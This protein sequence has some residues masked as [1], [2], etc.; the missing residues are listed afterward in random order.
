MVPSSH[1]RMQIATGHKKKR[2]EM[3]Q[4]VYN[5]SRIDNIRG[6]FLITMKNNFTVCENKQKNVWLI[7]A[8]STYFCFERVNKFD[9]KYRWSLP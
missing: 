2:R 1:V 9:G 3:L 4:F 6:M 5:L 8:Y 7:H